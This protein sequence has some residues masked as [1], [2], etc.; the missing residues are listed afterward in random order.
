M[1]RTPAASTVAEEIPPVACDV[2]EDRHPAVGLGARLPNEGN[3]G[4]RHSPV[5][6]VEVFDAKKEPDPAGCLVTDSS[7]LAF[8]VC[9]GEKK[10]GLCTG[11][12]NDHPPLWPPIVGERR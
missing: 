4:F 5:R 7:T 12:S 6:R 9:A 10:P 1:R 11:R 3:A 8:T 2:K